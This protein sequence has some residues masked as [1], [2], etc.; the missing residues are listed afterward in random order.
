MSTKHGLISLPL[1][2]GVYVLDMLANGELGRA[3][4]V[5]VG[6]EESGVGICVCITLA[7]ASF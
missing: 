6:Q 3:N 1:C 2:S 7:G 4:D 5:Q